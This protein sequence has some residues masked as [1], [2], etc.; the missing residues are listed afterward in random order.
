MTPQA[1]LEKLES[2]GTLE[3]GVLK[4][5]RR[6]VENPEKDSSVNKILTFLVK[7]EYLSKKEAIE[8]KREAESVAAVA[9]VENRTDELTAGVLSSSN[10]S[11][12]K[13]VDEAPEYEAE[14][15]E[16]VEVHGEPEIL[17]EGFDQ[18][19]AETVLNEPAAP[20]IDDLATFADPMAAP[21]DQF[22]DSKIKRTFAGKIDSSDQWATK[23]VFI[24]FATLGFLLMAGTLLF[25]FL[26]MISAVERFEAATQSFENGTYGDAI[27]KF[28]EFI[29]KHPSHEKIP[30]AKVKLVQSLLADTF[31]QNNWDETIVRAEK[32][33]PKLLEDDQID[34][35]PIRQDMAVILPNTTLEMA[36]RATKQETQ[37]GVS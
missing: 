28:E 6:T 17:E 10:Q 25:F 8:L 1:L 7:N 2:L 20:D 26:S 29:E 27:K 22:S 19:I 37:N 12:V 18:D 34:L 36:K 31:K 24:G 21:L 13:E 9:N 16:I 15:A 14:V 30:L 4:K 23:W 33:L 35:E 11:A 5:L 32:H 3:A